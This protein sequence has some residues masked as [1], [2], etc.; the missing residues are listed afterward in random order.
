MDKAARLFGAIASELGP[1][2]R[3]DAMMAVLTAWA[4]YTQGEV[5]LDVDPI[6]ATRYLDEALVLARRSGDRYLTGVALVSAR[7]DRTASS[8]VPTSIAV[9][10]GFPSANFATDTTNVTGLRRTAAAP[11]YDT[12]CFV[13]AQATPITYDLRLFDAAG[14]Q[15]GTTLSGAL[16]EF[17]ARK[18]RFGARA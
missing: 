12:N 8:T 11:T 17:E 3:L 9:V 15:I 4:T 2:L 14:T 6:P 10:E 13:A 7:S 16:N 1:A 18:R 5:R